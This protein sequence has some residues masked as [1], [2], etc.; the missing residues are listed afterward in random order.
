MR[1]ELLLKFPEL[2]SLSKSTVNE[3]LKMHLNLRY[4]RASYR[5]IQAGAYQMKFIK[6]ESARI[7]RFLMERDVNLVFVDEYLV[8][9]SL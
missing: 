7:I 4:K 6:R 1:I 3:A 2:S 5:P 9:S 8:G